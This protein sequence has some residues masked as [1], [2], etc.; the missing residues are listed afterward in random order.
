MEWTKDNLNEVSSR[1]GSVKSDIVEQSQNSN[2][3]LMDEMDK[4]ETYPDT[5]SIHP[6]AEEWNQPG[7]A[8]INEPSDVPVADVAD[9]TEAN[10]PSQDYA[11]RDRVGFRTRAPIS[12]DE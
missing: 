7:D 3:I 5:D 11:D 9:I 6:K 2:E 8:N 12:V 10:V 4:E 1:L